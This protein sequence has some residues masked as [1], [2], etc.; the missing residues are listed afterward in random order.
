M[1]VLKLK[2][3][4]DQRWKKQYIYLQPKQ[5]S[6]WLQI[7]KSPSFPGPSF[8]SARHLSVGFEDGDRLS[9]GLED[10]EGPS[11]GCGVGSTTTNTPAIM[12]ATRSVLGEHH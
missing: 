4:N 1:S 3:D 7:R 11:D 5:S 10:N 2:V 6:S 12:L 8:G 9:E